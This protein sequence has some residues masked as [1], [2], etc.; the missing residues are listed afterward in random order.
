MTLGKLFIVATPIGNLADITLRALNT[1][2]SVDF[3]CAEDTRTSQKLLQKYEIKKPLQAFH[4]HS[5]ERILNKIIAQ[6]KT[7]QNAAL[8]SDAGTPTISDPGFNLVQLA[9]A[10][11]LEVVPIPG[12][13]AVIT[14]LSAAG[15]PTDK[16]VFLGFPPA[17]KGRQTLFQSLQTEK[18]TVVFYE[19]P[20]RLAK[21]VAQLAE[22]LGAK[23]HLTLARELTKIHEEF[24]AGSLGAAQDWLAS[25]PKIRGE[26]V[27]I[28]APP[29]FPK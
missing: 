29:N 9:R 26:F 14:A 23:R 2:R 21:T 28:L 5:S 10:E 1:L 17:K 7:G 25:L 4:S 11:N 19:S 24:W 27:L 12:A 18:R 20:H 22:N 8:I 16:F 3:I 15:V 6:I 13:S